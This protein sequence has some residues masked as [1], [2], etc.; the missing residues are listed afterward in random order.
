MIPTSTVPHM[1]FPF[2]FFNPAQSL[3]VPHYQEDVN[4]VCAF[5]TGAG[6]TAIAELI[7]DHALRQ[8]KKAIYAAPLKALSQEKLD[9]WKKET[10]PFSQRRIS[11]VTGDYI[12]SKDRVEELHQ[13]DIVVLTSEMLDTRCRKMASERNSWLLDA[14]ACVIDEV[15]LI[16]I[17]DRGSALECGLMQFT[18]FNGN[19]RL[20][21]LSATIGNAEELADW[22][23]VLNHKK[24]L[25]FRSDYRPVPL[26]MHFIPYTVTGK[27]QKDHFA[28]RAETSARTLREHPNDRFLIFVHSKREGRDLTKY[29]QDQGWSVDFHCADLPKEKR[30]R[31]EKDFR[32]GDLTHLVS[33]NTLA[34]GVNLPARRVLVLGTQR[35][36]TEVHPADLQQEVGRAGRPGFDT[37]G[38]AHILLPA[39]T[40]DKE[41][42]KFESDILVSSQLVYPWT[43]SFHLVSQIEQG[44]VKTRGDIGKWFG[45]SFAAFREQSL[46][47]ELVNKTIED[48]LLWGAIEV[49]QSGIFR[50]LPI[51]LVAAWFYYLPHDIASWM[52]NFKLILKKGH[53]NVDEFDLA[54]AL[55]TCFSNSQN[56][57]IP[58]EVHKKI[59]SF[60]ES[61]S[62]R[63]YPLNDS[64][65]PFVI[66]LWCHMRGQEDLG[67]LSGF[68]MEV[69]ND[70]DRLLQAIQVVGQ[71]TGAY[72]PP[73]SFWKMAKTMISKGVPKERAALASVKG[74]GRVYSQELF[75]R[76]IRTPQDIV[77]E[78]STV[79]E[80]LGKSAGGKI[81]QEAERMLQED[82]DDWK[83]DD[84]AARED[85]AG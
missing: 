67:D 45:R 17:E 61:N 6:K 69:R 44:M 42:L 38:D 84:L 49:S 20:V 80:L 66:G 57:Y 54:W 14:G 29:L 10:H 26:R 9:L 2:P 52:F 19:A 85:R 35:G 72:N 40:L 13:A 41:R 74:V 53:D 56:A 59:R 51:G 71:K 65:S 64:C 18:R 34:W 5:K 4:I 75:W 22:A 24:T 33:T 46:S 3:V 27:R 78:A 83:D 81:V 30:L 15:H 25:L 58:Y 76:G 7:M 32:E 23:T 43:L 37:E 79:T 77:R 21:F 68:T 39:S 11:I 36:G 8:G 82:H 70:V 47:E 62:G 55:G 31:L 73:K 16:T 12:L 48:L 60:F 50:C 1:K 28:A 63:N